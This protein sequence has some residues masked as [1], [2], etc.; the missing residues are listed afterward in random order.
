MNI[1]EIVNKYK[2]EEDRGDKIKIYDSNKPLGMHYGYYEKNTKTY[3]EAVINMDNQIANL[4]NLNIVKSSY[5]VLDAGCGIGATI[6]FLANKFPKINFYGINITPGEITLAKEFAKENKVENNTHF[7]IDDYNNTIFEKDFFD[8]IFAL[9]SLSY[10]KNKKKF[11][12]EAKRIL[13]PGGKLIIIDGFL[14]KDELNPFMQKMYKNFWEHK[15]YYFYSEN[16]WRRKHLYNE[17]DNLPELDSVQ[18]IISFLEELGFVDIIMKD[19]SKNIS[20]SR[21]WVSVNKIKNI[22]SSSKLEK[23]IEIKKPISKKITFSSIL[24]FNILQILFS[25]KKATTYCEITAIKK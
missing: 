17:W 9:E 6:I 24:I 8:G 18:K 20:L 25:L 7:F 11:F 4:L 2:R 10:S 5:N 14:K 1:E 16:E 15:K 22:F 19:I 3:V 21:L 13:K 12:I 23:D